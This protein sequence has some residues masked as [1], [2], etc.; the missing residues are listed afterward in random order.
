MTGT[1]KPEI[2]DLLREAASG[3]LAA[4]E[5]LLQRH[6][7]CLL[8]MV[9]LRMDARLACRID[10]SDVVQEA[11]LEAHRRLD[12]YLEERPVAFYPWLRGIA[13]DLLVG[14]Y[15]RHVLSRKRSITREEVCPLPDS[16]TAELADRLMARGSSPS[17]GVMREELRQGVREALARLPDADREVLV[18]RHLEQLS[19][20]EMA[21]VLGIREGA[22]SVRVLR[23]LRRLRALLGDDF[24]KEMS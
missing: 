7:S 10:P 3:N 11:L 1:S 15:R 13:W 24:L 16:S 2:Q 19:I 4:R 5:A 14:L 12:E 8:R 9:A 22:V 18:L 20:G 21:D 23:A 6:R 17:A